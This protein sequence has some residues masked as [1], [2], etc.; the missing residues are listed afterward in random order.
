[1]KL[2][3]LLNINLLIIAVLLVFQWDSLGQSRGDCEEIKVEVKVTDTNGDKSNG[4][5][6]ITSKDQ[7]LTFH[8]L[9]V[10]SPKSNRL[11][12]K[13]NHIENLSKGEYE[14]IVTGKEGS[15]YCPYRQR[16]NVN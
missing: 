7:D 3:N 1:M 15:N 10:G 16:I 11:N 6:E 4:S 13:S 2:R 8:L 12:I 14:L 5:I 9:E